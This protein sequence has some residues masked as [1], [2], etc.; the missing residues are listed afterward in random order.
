MGCDPEMWEWEA[1]V[2]F[3]CLFRGGRGQTLDCFG[4]LLFRVDKFGVK[5]FGFSVYLSGVSELRGRFEF[6]GVRGT[7]PRGFYGFRVCSTVLGPRVL[8]FSGLGSYGLMVVGLG[9]Q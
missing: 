5:D 8:G 4:V 3:V 7:D 9:P 2:S 6:V 1:L